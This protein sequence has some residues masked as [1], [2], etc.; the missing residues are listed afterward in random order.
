M[1]EFDGPPRDGTGVD[2]GWFD[3]QGLERN[4]VWRADV[5]VYSVVSGMRIRRDKGK[6]GG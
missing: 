4:G 6:N 1:C 3:V 2:V 5:V